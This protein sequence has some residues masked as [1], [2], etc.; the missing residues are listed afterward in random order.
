M[1]VYKC[2]GKRFHGGIKCTNERENHLP[3]SWITISGKIKNNHPQSHVIE[4]NGTV[5]FCSREC[6][7]LFFF[8]D[9]LPSPPIEQSME[10]IKI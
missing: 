9:Q 7:E 5:H 8:K 3:E 10:I 6:L 4:F 2:D 1:I